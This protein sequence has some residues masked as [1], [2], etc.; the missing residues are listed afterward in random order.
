MITKDTQKGFGIANQL[1]SGAQE[2]LL[3]LKEIEEMA[4]KYNLKVTVRMI[5]SYIFREYIDK[6]MRMGRLVYYREDYIIP[7]ITC[8]LVLKM[9]FK[10]KPRKVYL[11][12]TANRGNLDS[13]LDRLQFFVE[14]YI[15]KNIPNYYAELEKF[16]L[17]ALVKGDLAID[18]GLLEKL[19]QE[20]HE[21]L[22]NR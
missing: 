20:E 16:F 8:I 1:I 7:A 2:K 4:K 21:K 10:L 18:F 22:V 14:T 6:P 9:R 11:I 17:E 3:S 13:L 12:M 5:H 19:A 15:N